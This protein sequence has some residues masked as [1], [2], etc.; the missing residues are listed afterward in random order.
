[1]LQREAAATDA[2]ARR[3]FTTTQQSFA[4]LRRGERGLQRPPLDDIESFWSPAEKQLAT[5]MLAFSVV[6]SPDTVR[7]G[8]ARIQADTRAEEL[9][10]VS[11]IFDS[12]ARIRSYEIVAEAMSA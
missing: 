8:I 11:G 5:Q 3:L 4:L 9:I 2:E 1:M 12:A 6:G 10:V 7:A